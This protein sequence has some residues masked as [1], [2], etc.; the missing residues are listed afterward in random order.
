VES[1]DQCAP[2]KC[3]GLYLPVSPRDALADECDAFA[4]HFA[5]APTFL[6]R[7]RQQT[8][9]AALVV[10]DDMDFT[11][12]AAVSKSLAAAMTEEE[13]C[14]L[15]DSHTVLV[16]RVVTKCLALQQEEEFGLLI[17][18][19]AKL[20]ELQALDVSALT[21]HTTAHTAAALPP[22]HAAL[23]AGATS[24]E[25]TREC[26]TLITQ[27]KVMPHVR[28]AIRQR[29]ELRARLHAL[30]AYGDGSHLDWEGV[31]RAGSAL[32]VADK[33]VNAPP[34]TEEDYLT[35]ADRRA[36]LLQKA[37]AHCRALLSAKDYGKLSNMAAKLAKLKARK[38]AS[39]S[40]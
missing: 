23:S 15:K 4:A 29:D 34:L 13:Y 19:G 8:D 33:A 25:I 24:E 1:F 9:L 37:T 36:A 5:R 18:L 10:A 35:L 38:M 27:F 7:S 6:R 2:V 14:T 12:I 11:A 21:A 17:L 22:S 26:V 30:T 16:D 31:G 32:K 39:T 20:K 28:L 3:S 40:N